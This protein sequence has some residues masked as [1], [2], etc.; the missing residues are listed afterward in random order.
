MSDLAVIGCGYV[1][2]VSAAC[3]ASLG[4]RVRA[5]DI[6]EERV[7]R[8]RHAD[9]PFV[10]A[11]LRELVRHEQDAGRLAF[12]VDVADAV[13]GAD[14][15]LICVATPTAP[16]GESD[17]TQL[18]GALVAIAPALRHDAVVVVRSTVP[19]GTGDACAD[20]LRDASPE[21]AGD[22]VTN[23]EFLREGTAVHDFLH[24]DRLVF[25]G[26]AAAVAMVEDLS[27]P[28]LAQDDPLVFRMD[29][30]SA[31]LV[32]AGANAALAAKISLA[33]EVADLCE[34]T[35][36]DARTV[37]PAIG[38]DTRIGA[39]WLGPGLGWGGSCLPKDLAALIATGDRVGLP[40][41]LLRAVGAVNVDRVTIAMRK[42]RTHL[43]PLDGRR[44]AVLGVAFKAGTDDLRS[45]PSLALCTRLLDEGAT[46]SASDPLVRRLPDRWASIP[47]FPDPY[48]AVRNA[49]AV[50]VTVPSNVAHDLDPERVANAMRG[51]LVLDLPNAL[52]PAA[53]ASAGL[54]VVGTGWAPAALT[55]AEVFLTSPQG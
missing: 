24:P 53:F 36:A 52:D 6:D 41:P 15:V 20:A 30:R 26:P 31:E 38:A 46:V 2:S 51:D 32:K 54:A 10:E 33:N 39:S 19:V 55:A 49:D 25:G 27:R 23:P 47:L 8:L 9:P 45:S 22:V 35:G 11:G 7:T 17:L 14:V 3:L 1:G 21:W 18:W 12:G 44:I 37:L 28:L 50:V 4:H 5:V 29:R 48:G 42:L 13:R 16:S 40:T 34:R 43:G